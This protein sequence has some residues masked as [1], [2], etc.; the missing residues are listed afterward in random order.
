M[1]FTLLLGT[2]QLRKTILSRTENVL[3]KILPNQDLTHSQLRAGFGP[4]IISHMN[5]HSRLNLKF[6]IFN[7]GTQ[8]VLDLQNELLMNLN[9]NIF[10]GNV[11][12]IH[13]RQNCF[14]GYKTL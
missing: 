3:T 13:K 7:T 4:Q 6:I 5:I 12:L 9:T 11:K 10:H 14:L 1:T 2:V 8:N